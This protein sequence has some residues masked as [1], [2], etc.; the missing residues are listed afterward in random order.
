M[1][2]HDIFKQFQRIV[3]DNDYAKRSRAR[4]V[5]FA[6]ETPVSSPYRFLPSLRRV[7][8][9]LE[10]GFAI[11]LTGFLLVLALGGFSFLRKPVGVAGLDP[12]G[13]RAEAEAIDIQIQLSDLNYSEAVQAEGS[14]NESTVAEVVKKAGQ[15]I[16]VLKDDEAPAPSVSIDDALDI[17]A[18]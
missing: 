3:P 15:A 18:E 16:G 17:L 7:I 12:A 9:T 8:W 4:L 2:L 5:I 6:R 11:A 1:N 10:S 13:L 14:Q